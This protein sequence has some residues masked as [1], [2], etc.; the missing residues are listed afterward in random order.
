M[1]LPSWF[2]Q[3][4]TR[5]RPG[6]KTVRG[7]AVPDWD[8]A[9]QLTI[10]NCSV[11]PSTTSLSQDGRVLGIAESYT[12]YMPV[13]ADVKEGDRIVYLNN[14]YVVRGKPSV[15]VSATGAMDNKQV[16]LERWEG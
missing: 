5:L 1:T 12:L 9:S 4:V 10:G 8:A 16:I 2:R 15:W 14:T 7:S 13:D 11:Q 3:C 6:T